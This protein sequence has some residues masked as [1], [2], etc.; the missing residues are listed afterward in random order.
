MAG[1]KEEG[2][3]HL[4]KIVACIHSDVT[5]EQQGEI[6]GLIERC[7]NLQK[8]HRR[9]LYHNLALTNTIVLIILSNSQSNLPP[10]G[11]RGP[12]GDPVGPRGGPEGGGPRGGDPA[13]PPGGPPGGPPR[14]GGPLGPGPPAVTYS[15]YKSQVNFG[16]QA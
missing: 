15:K 13:G 8:S 2:H 3:G 11:P 4:I 9:I 10:G 5:S 16:E 6:V 12:P 14:G 1:P 7:R